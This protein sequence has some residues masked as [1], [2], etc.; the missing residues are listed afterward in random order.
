[1]QN[2]GRGDPVLQGR[3]SLREE[4]QNKGGVQPDREEPLWGIRPSARGKLRVEPQREEAETSGRSQAEL[5]RRGDTEVRTWRVSL[6]RKWA[7]WRHN[8]QLTDI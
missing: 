2:E 7:E 6:G 1:M 3:P 8:C 4:A 5:N